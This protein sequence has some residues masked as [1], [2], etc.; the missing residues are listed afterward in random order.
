M[1][2]E[3]VALCLTAVCVGVVHT[4]AGPDHSIPFVAMARAGG[5]SAAK[6]F[7]VTAACG[8]GHV[9]GSAV[10]GIVGLTVGSMVLGGETLEAL[11]G[12]IASSMLIGLG[13]AYFAWGVIRAA[14]AHAAGRSRGRFTGHSHGP[15]PHV[16]AIAGG[17]D[18]GGH[19]HG[20]TVGSWTPWMLFLIFIF[21]PSEPL[22]PLLMVPA[23]RS[24]PVAVAAVVT[25]FACATVATMTVS[26]M[27]MRYGTSLVPGL[28]IGRFDQ[29]VA[30]LAMLACG[31]LVKFGL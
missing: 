4:A 13:M 30:G 11:R 18:P 16:H 29:A 20:P 14:D 24:G 5:W 10:L 9:A 19:D 23:S 8:L 2:S 1:T 27:L 21:G 31:V 15:F 22:V 25:A 26:V 28:L 6:T 12:D 17:H 3:F 7:W